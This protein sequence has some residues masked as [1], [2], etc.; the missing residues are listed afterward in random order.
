MGGRPVGR[1]QAGRGQ[2]DGG[3]ASRGP[4]AQRAAGRRSR[5]DHHVSGTG[6]QAHG[7]GEFRRLPGDEIAVQPV[8]RALREAARRRRGQLGSFRRRNRSCSRARRRGHGRSRSTDQPVR[9]VGDRVVR[10]AHRHGHGTARA[11]G[12]DGGEHPFGDPAVHLLDDG[13][14]PTQRL[15]EQPAHPADLVSPHG[16]LLAHVHQQRGRCRTRV[17]PRAAGQ[18]GA[19]R[20]LR[21]SLR[22]CG[23]CAQPFSSGKSSSRNSPS[24]RAGCSSRCRSS[25]RRILPETVLGSVPNSSRRTRLNGDRWSRQYRRMSRAV[26]SLASHPAA[27]VTYALGTAWR[28]GSGAGHHGRFGNGAV[29]EQHALQLE[30]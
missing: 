14:A 16:I 10:R 6:E 7:P 15:T 20:A 26:S 3:Q 19:G 24:G 9:H 1:G 28:S 5:A 11:A 30:R 12:A 21:R 13:G 25:T 23:G 18:S 29:L 8:D 4:G 17:A 27:R 2:A 22:G